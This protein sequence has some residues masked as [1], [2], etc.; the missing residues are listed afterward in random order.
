MTDRTARPDDEDPEWEESSWDASDFDDAGQD[1][2]GQDDA[3][4]DEAGSG[5]PGSGRPGL[6]EDESETD[7]KDG[8]RI[9]RGTYDLPFT[10]T[11]AIVAFLALLIVVVASSRYILGV[12]VSGQGEMPADSWVD[13][14]FAQRARFAGALTTLAL[15]ALLFVIGSAL[16]AIEVRAGLRA[17]K[18]ADLQIHGHNMNAV[19][20]ILDKFP[21]I[22]KAASFTRS[23]ALLI[24]GATFIALGAVFLMSTIEDGP[25]GGGTSDDAESTSIPTTDSAPSEP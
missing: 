7:D 19:E 13:G 1:D 2:A 17:E 12:E 18:S 25:G 22:L 8:V 16:A 24:V 20:S 10:V 3:G 21:E 6:D 9:V 4:Q 11:V 5:A 15:A 23:T 14:S